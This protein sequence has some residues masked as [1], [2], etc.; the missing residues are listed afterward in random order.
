MT[1]TLISQR[2]NSRRR[3]CDLFENLDQMKPERIPNDREHEF[4]IELRVILFRELFHLV[5]A[6]RIH[7]PYSGK[8]K[9]RRE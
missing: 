5:V 6:R 2:Y 8:T 4:S 7:N 1:M 3:T 9:T